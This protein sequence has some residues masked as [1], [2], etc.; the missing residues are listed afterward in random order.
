MTDEER[1][2]RDLINALRDAADLTR[3][4]AEAMLAH[5]IRLGYFAGTHA[6]A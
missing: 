1:T 4:Q 2:Y 3:A 5:A 6:S